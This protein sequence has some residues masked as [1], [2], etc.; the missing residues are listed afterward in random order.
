M[1]SSFRNNK[2]RFSN[3]LAALLVLA[4][5]PALRGQNSFSVDIDASI[6][7][8]CRPS[9]NPATSSVEVHIEELTQEETRS[10]TLQCSFDALS[11]N[12]RQVLRLIPH[13]LERPLVLTTDWKDAAKWQILKFKN[14]IALGGITLPPGSYKITALLTS[15]DLPRPV[16]L[17]E[18]DFMVT[19]SSG[20]SIRRFTIRP[21][22]IF[23]PL[24]SKLLGRESLYI[25]IITVL[26]GL[27]TAA[28]KK[29]AEKVLDRILDYLGSFGRGKLAERRFLKRYNDYLYSTHRYLRLLG[30]AAAGVSRPQLEQVFIS[31]RVSGFDRSRNN[32][33]PNTGNGTS[34]ENAVAENPRLALLGGPGAGKTTT[35]SYIVLQ[36]VQGREREL[37]R[38]RAPLLPIFVP[39]RRVSN[40]NNSLLDDILSPDTQ[41]IPED[42][43]RAC[44]PGFLERRLN[45]GRCVVLLDGLD[46]VIDDETHKL[47]ALKINRLVSD[48]PKNRFV[49]TCRIAGWRNLLDDFRV[50]EAEDFNRN[51]VH[52]FIFG[53]HRAIV[54]QE[55]RNKIELKYQDPEER[56]TAWA[57]EREEIQNNIDSTSRKLINAVE[58]SPRLMAVAT[59]P[60]LLSLI[61]LVHWVKDVLPRE[62]PILYERCLELLV[63]AWD[64][65]RNISSG[66][67]LAA[68]Q[69]EAV[70]R[71]TALAFQSSGKGEASRSQVEQI[72]AAEISKLGLQVQSKE[73]LEQIE[74]R[75]GILVERS[76]DV[77]GFSHLTLQEYLVAK[78][79]QLNPAALGYLWKNFDNQEWR[80]VILLYAGLIDD[81]TA[82]VRKIVEPENPERWLLAGYTLGE[83]RY[84]DAALTQSV[85]DHVI[86]DFFKSQSV[87]DT[88][89]SVLA[90]LCADYSGYPLTPEQR[91]SA[92]MIACVRKQSTTTGAAIRVLSKAR[93]TRAIDPIV[94]LLGYGGELENEVV[95]SLVLFGNI[96]LPAISALIKVSHDKR[97]LKSVIRVLQ[98]IDTSEAAYVL[99]QCFGYWTDQSD[100]VAISFAL[101]AMIENEYIA[102]DLQAVL[103]SQMGSY[104]GRAFVMDSIAWPF[105]EGESTAFDWLLLKV[106]DDITSELRGAMTSSTGHLDITGF[107]AVFPA[108]ALVLVTRNEKLS[109]EQWS[110]LG[111]KVAS[112]LDLT[113]LTR[114]HGD[115]RAAP[116]G[117]K[118]GIRRA[119]RGSAIK[120]ASKIVRVLR[121][122]CEVLLSLL[123]A[124]NEFIAVLFFAGFLF[125]ERTEAIKAT[126]I[127]GVGLVGGIF[128][129][130]IA[131]VIYALR[132]VGRRKWWLAI[133]SPVPQVLRRAPYFTPMKAWANFALLQLVWIGLSV[134]SVLLANAVYLASSRHQNSLR[135]DPFDKSCFS[136][137]LL[138]VCLC[139]W[140]YKFQVLRVDAPA[141]LLLKHP[142]GRKILGLRSEAAAGD[143][144]AIELIPDAARDTLL[145]NEGVPART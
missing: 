53:W 9:L 30:F 139:A 104:I 68:Y 105:H 5:S 119:I 11:P 131:S 51:E 121:R 120:E 108:I 77:L 135:F 93:M 14:S 72:I 57:R 60:M 97:L 15:S 41:I 27:L 96:A 115:L 79:I 117:V 113:V 143:A 84:C 106:R 126:D 18:Q 33:L 137:A 48:Y 61:C 128:A 28:L 89:V 132:V 138:F 43:L 46:E 64:R 73:L 40:R 142:L 81:A 144:N 92:E 112:D 36:C 21:Q 75:S 100:Q 111:F 133:V 32:I 114:I 62:R 22:S 87:P 71:G 90:A 110:V 8:N 23:D 59:N 50:L 145:A 54:T 130:W 98:Q 101:A 24:K 129:V 88:L 124:F 141:L 140:F 83:A 35:L 74:Q 118:E 3:L 16:K 55:F 39:L 20:A 94:A 2:A 31:L 17:L 56:A 134:P 80:E 63:D 103:G 82:L 6:F 76:I 34:F 125:V 12:Q 95:T 44:P 52:R 107:K 4:A 47:A 29:R 58:S 66:M 42:I 26:A 19:K 13:Y 38:T 86:Q 25:S 122:P 65:S 7:E 69:K 1:R 45:E 85:L 136:L 123:T 37:L 67:T 99:I 10:F 116:A 70:L 127:L 78:H 109:R 102:S 91:L 49:V